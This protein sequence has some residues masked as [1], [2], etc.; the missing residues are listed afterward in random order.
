VTGPLYYHDKTYIVDVVREL[1][2]GREPSV[3]RCPCQEDCI[4]IVAYARGQTGAVWFRTNVSFSPSPDVD[5][6]GI[7]N[8]EDFA[9][10]LDD[11]RSAPT[12]EFFAIWFELG[13]REA[14]LNELESS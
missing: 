13:L 5:I 11:E 3:W 6:C 2:G 9:A 7:D 4:H 8:V 12:R 10:F 1:A 14:I